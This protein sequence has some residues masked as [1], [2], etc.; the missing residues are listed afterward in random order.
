M[1]TKNNDVAFSKFL[2]YVL[3]H[4]PKVIGLELMTDGWV[5]T[6][7]LLKALETNSGYKVDLERLKNV[8]DTDEKKRYSFKEM[9]GDPYALIRANQGHSVTGL[10]MNYR[11]VKDLP[12]V[13]Y[14]GTSKDN[15]AKIFESGSIKPMSRQLVHLSKDIETAT[16]VGKRH[17]ELEILEIDIKGLVES[18]HKLFISE[19]GVY[20]VD[21]VPVEFIISSLKE[22]LVYID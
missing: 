21:E 17:G 7:E 5:D 6:Y 11:E 22:R 14:H 1:G 9:H 8:V 4:N 10:E 16:K 13:L 20:L 18:G 12:D 19:N 2:S 3:R 15:A